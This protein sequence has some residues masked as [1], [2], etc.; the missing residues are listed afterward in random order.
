[1]GLGKIEGLLILLGIILLLFGAKNLPKLAKSIGESVQELKRGFRE[2]PD[3]A[4][5]T[6]GTKVASDD[7]S[8]KA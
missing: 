8:K 1:M 3:D 7:S 4:P 6:D 5:S 2:S